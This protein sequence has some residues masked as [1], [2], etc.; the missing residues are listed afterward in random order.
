M[1]QPFTWTYHCYVVDVVVFVDFHFSHQFSLWDFRSENI[2]LSMFKWCAALLCLL[3]SPHWISHTPYGG[4]TAST[5]KYAIATRTIVLFAQYIHNFRSFHSFAALFNTVSPLSRCISLHH[6]FF[7]SVGTFYFQ[8]WREER[9]CVN[10]KISFNY[11]A[12]R[13]TIPNA[14]STLCSMLSLSL[15]RGAFR[16]SI[17]FFGALFHFRPEYF[18]IYKRRMLAVMVFMGK[19][20]Y[21]FSLQMEK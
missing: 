2:C 7:Y 12:Q 15:L 20:H 4:G 14:V 17:V 6:S 5:V 1:P 8:L 13:Q 9:T 10:Q 16:F 3:H 21:A 19:S 11:R 18:T